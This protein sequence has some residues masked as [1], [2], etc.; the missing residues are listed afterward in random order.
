VALLVLNLSTSALAVDGFY[1]EPQALGVT[2]LTLSGPAFLP[3]RP[4]R[5]VHLTDL[6]VERLT[7]RERDLVARVAALQPDLIVLTGDYINQEYLNDPAARQAARE[8]L[9]QLHAPRGV[10]AVAGTID[11]PETMTALFDGLD[12]TV[13]DNAAR[14]LPFEGGELYLMGVTH[15]PEALQAL[16]AQAPAGAY[17]LL[18]HHMPDLIETAAGLG[19]DAYLAG[20]THGGQVRLPLYGA[21]VT[22][23]AYGKRFEMGRYTVGSTTLYVSRGIGMEGA[24][25]PRVRFL[26]RPELELLSVGG[27][28][29]SDP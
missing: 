21:L 8:V 17:T 29:F 16:M 7:R 28:G 24:N 3:D 12:I 6:H 2:K 13:L 4:L 9:S 23:S 25:L 14:R 5:L 10:Y 27:P 22:F 26:C 19:V 1:V 18:L 15:S 11:A 20:H